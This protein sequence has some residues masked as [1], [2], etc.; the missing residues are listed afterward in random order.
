MKKVILKIGGMSCSA[1]QNRVEK[2]LNKQEGVKASVN[3]VLAQALIEYDEQLVKIEDLERFIKESGYKSLGIYN[4]KEEEKKDNTKYYLIILAV[5]IIGLMY[6]SMSHIIKNSIIYGITLLILTI[7]FIIFGLDIMISGINKLFHK[8]PNMDSLVTL[9]VLT[10]FLYSLINL[11]LIISGNNS[12]INQLYFESSAMIIYFIKLGR[13]I[14]KNSKEKTK[15]AIKELV[16]ITPQSALLKIN[17]GEK[18]VTIDEVKKGDIL[19]CKPG[20]K[21]AVDG[22]IIKG[23]AHLD[24]AFITGEALSKKKKKNDKVIAGS[25]NIDGYIEYKA[26]RI[27]PDSTISEIVRL[28]VESANTKAPIQ[29]IAD[30]FS[31]IFVPSIITIAILSL[32]GYLLIGRD[33]NESILSFVTVLLVACPCALGLATPLAIVVSIG[34]REYLK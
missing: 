10:S 20:M 29:K 34:R 22:L 24:E 15:E 11:L 3:L 1:C 16:E 21:I 6:L 5:I 7:P 32:I 4:E 19:I 33:I 23:E 8:S 9:G 13:Y 2:Y 12:L 18:E 27:G 31:S 25:I 14:D 30:K 26:E 17:D 28:V